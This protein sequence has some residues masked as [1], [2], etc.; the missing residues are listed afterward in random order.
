MTVARLEWLSALADVR[1]EELSLVSERGAAFQGRLEGRAATTPLGLPAVAWIGTVE[2]TRRR[3]KSSVS[4]EK[5]R[6]GATEG[7]SLVTSAGRIPIVAPN[8]PS[9]DV[10][11]SGTR[12]LPRG[13]IWWLRDHRTVSPLPASVIAACSLRADDLARDQWVYAED[14]ATAG[15]EMGFA[16]CPLRRRPRRVRDGSEARGT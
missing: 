1:S 15:D 4:S 3:A 14:R 9:I 7:L 11:R 5:C 12:A 10:D 16:G 6:I 2:V 8:L 13:R